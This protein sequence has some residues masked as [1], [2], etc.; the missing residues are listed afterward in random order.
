MKMSKKSQR[1]VGQYNPG[2]IEVVVTGY[3]ERRLD[4]SGR[5]G[6]ESTP[7]TTSIMP[8]TCVAEKYGPS[9]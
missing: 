6:I 9:I 1:I 2:A 5:G 7:D 4:R 3:G 8:K